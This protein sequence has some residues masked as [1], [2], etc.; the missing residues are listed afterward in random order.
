MFEALALVWPAID[1]EARRQLI[2]FPQV[3]D[4]LRQ[5][6]FFISPAVL[7]LLLA[8]FQKPEA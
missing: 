4:Q 5:T 2:N 3:L 6:N 1:L 7:Q 8:R